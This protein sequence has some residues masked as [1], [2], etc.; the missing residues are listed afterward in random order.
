[1]LLT[2]SFPR[3][4]DDK[5]RFA[6]PKPLRDAIGESDPLSLYI[7]PGTEGSLALYPEE[8]FQHLANRVE[9][10]V[11]DGRDLAAFSRLF[12]AQAQRVELDRQG[13]VRLPVELAELAGLRKE[14][15]LLGVRDHLEIWNRE[16]WETYLTRTQPYYDDL[17]A[18]VLAGGA[19]IVVPD[20]PP[21]D[22]LS[23]SADPAKRPGQPR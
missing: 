19:S 8:T 6:I 3:L 1:M 18:R 22:I 4:L 5:C 23:N 16:L 10:G 7:A 2:G 11:S 20:T 9:R 14:I 17:A 12:Y 21:A 15:M 13:R